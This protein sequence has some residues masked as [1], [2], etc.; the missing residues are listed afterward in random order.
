MRVGM[1]DL[2]LAPDVFWTLTPA[3]LVL[4]MGQSGGVAPMRR[5][6]LEAL[7]AAYPDKEKGATGDRD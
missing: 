3:E 7:M 4:L 5:A 1:R 2:G 6:G